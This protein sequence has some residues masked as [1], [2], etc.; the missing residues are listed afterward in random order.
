MG[1]G[2]KRRRPNRWWKGSGI[3]KRARWKERDDAVLEDE[4]TGEG[5]GWDDDGGIAAGEVQSGTETSFQNDDGEI[6]AADRKLAEGENDGMSVFEKHY[7]LQGLFQTD[8]EWN[9]FMECLKHPLPVTFRVN[10]GLHSKEVVDACLKEAEAFLHSADPES[11][12]RAEY[13]GWSDTYKLSVDRRA[14]KTSAGDT[15]RYPSFVRMLHPSQRLL[16]PH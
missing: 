10:R 8:E 6:A 5:E 3:C 2:Q 13:L 9:V 12:C 1:S 16:P 15:L 4:A 11:P 7:R 14:L